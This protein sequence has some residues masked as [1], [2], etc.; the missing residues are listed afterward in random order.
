MMD[1]ELEVDDMMYNRMKEFLTHIGPKSYEG[2]SDH[3][4]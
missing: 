2:I 4:N 1:S 3:R